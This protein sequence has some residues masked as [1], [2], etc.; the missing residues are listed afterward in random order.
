MLLIVLYEA[1]RPT[2]HQM[3][4]SDHE[5]H[6]RNAKKEK[7]SHTMFVCENKELAAIYCCTLHHCNL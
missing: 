5:F 4:E 1:S 2:K 3:V 7:Q 6:L